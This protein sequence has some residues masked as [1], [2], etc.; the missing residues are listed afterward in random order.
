[1][2]N[3]LSQ[4]ADTIIKKIAGEDFDA[5]MQ[6]IKFSA[7]GNV[8]RYSPGSQFLIYDRKPD[9]VALGSYDTWV[10]FNRKPLAH[11]SI[12]IFKVDNLDKRFQNFNGLIW[13]VSDTYSK[14]DFNV[15]WDFDDISRKYVTSLWG[16]ED[17]FDTIKNLT[18]TYVRDIFETEENKSFIA[19]M[20]GFIISS[21]LGVDYEVSDRTEKYY[22][23]LK[24]EEKY[25]FIKRIQKHIQKLS[26]NAI[27]FADKHRRA[28]KEGRESYDFSK[29]KSINSDRREIYE[30]EQGGIYGSGSE[31]GYGSSTVTAD[32]RSR[33]NS[34]DGTS[35]GTGIRD[36]RLREGDLSGEVRDDDGVRGDASIRET[37]SNGSEGIKDADRREVNGEERKSI[38][39]TNNVDGNSERGSFVQTTYVGQLDLFNY[40][41]ISK[42]DTVDSHLD[43][44]HAINKSISTSKI[45]Q[46]YIDDVIKR[47]TGTV[48][49]KKR[50][51]D[52]F[53]INTHSSTEKV[54]FLK[55]EL[56]NY[57]AG[58]PL[59][60]FGLHGYD[61]LPSKGIEFK[62]RDQDGEKSGVVSYPNYAKRVQTLINT[63]KYFNEPML[64]FGESLSHDIGINL[65]A[66]YCGK[67]IAS[68]KNHI[69]IFNDNTLS[70]KEKFYAINNT[71]D[72]FF[73]N[74]GNNN[75]LSFKGEVEDTV[76][77]TYPAVLNGIPG[78]AESS[79]TYLE[80]YNAID[81]GLKNN[82]ELKN[83]AENTLLTGDLPAEPDPFAGT[84]TEAIELLARK[85]NVFDLQ[86][87]MIEAL[88]RDENINKDDI[89]QYL[90]HISVSH[91]MC[92][93]N[94]DFGLV[95]YSFN[96]NSVDVSFK[97]YDGKRH[98][99]SFTYDALVNVF[100]DVSK[101]FGFADTQRTAELHKKHS[102][103]GVYNDCIK[104]YYEFLD[105]LFTIKDKKMYAAIENSNICPDHSVGFINKM[106]G[107]NRYRIVVLGNEGGLQCYPDK[108]TFFDTFEEAAVFINSRAAEFNI[109]DY[110]RIADL[111]GISSSQIISED[112]FVEKVEG[113]VEDAPVNSNSESPY[114]TWTVAE[115][116][117]FHD[118]GEYYDD[119]ESLDEAVKLFDSIPSERMNGIKA[120]GIQ[121]HNLGIDSIYDDLQLDVF[122]GSSIDLE[123]FDDFPRLK[124][125]DLAINKL[126]EIVAM[127]PMC[128]TR[129]VLPETSNNFSADIELGQSVFLTDVDEQKCK[130]SYFEFVITDISDDFV[131]L[132]NNIHCQNIMY[133]EKVRKYAGVSYD[134]AKLDEYLLNEDSLY[135]DINI[136]DTCIV[137]GKIATID[138]RHN[139]WGQLSLKC[140]YDDGVHII[141]MGCSSFNSLREHPVIE[142]V[143]E[144]YP[145]QKI[146]IDGTEFIVQEVRDNDVQLLDPLLVY[147]VFRVESKD[148]VRSY[149]STSVNSL[150]SED[151]S[152]ISYDSVTD[153]FDSNEISGTPVNF[154][155][156]DTYV[157]NTG[158]DIS[159]FDKNIEAIK[160]LKV[161]ESENRFATK[162]EQKVL[163]QYIG[164]GGLSSCFDEDKN[165]EQFNILKEVLTEDEFISARA[166]TTD[167]FYT[168]REVISS[169]YTALENMGFSGGNVLEPSCGIGN[170]ISGMPSDMRKNS[171]I[172]GVEIDSISG[173]IAKALHPNVDI[174]IT[175]FEKSVLQ[176]NF[177]DVVI[178]NIPFGDFKVYDA[179]YNK[180]NFLIHDYFIAKC[181]DKV[182][183][184]GIVA[185][186]TS[187]GTLDKNNSKVRQ[188]FAERAELLGAIR[189][190]SN[191]FKAG[192]NTEATSDILFF[193]KKASRSIENSET[194]PWLDLGYTA[195]DIAVNQY[196]VDKPFMC[197]GKMVKDTSRF[198]PDRAITSCEA[199]DDGDSLYQKM[200]KA[201]NMLPDIKLD[202]IK[203]DEVSADNK[204]GAIPA[205]DSV[206]NNTYTVI[207]DEVYYRINS[208][209]YPQKGEMS[210][211]AYERVKGLCKVREVFHAYMDHQIARAS[212]D[213]IKED[214]VLLN[215]VYDDF[216]K[217]FGYI[218]KVGN[219]RANEL[220]FNDDVE[221]ALL[222]SLE[223]V[224]EEGVTKAECFNKQTIRPVIKIDKVD[225]AIDALNITLNEENTVDIHQMLSLYDVTFEQLISELKGKIYR[226]PVK[227]DEN[228]NFTGWES[229][230]EYLSGNVR[231][232]LEQAKTAA[233]IYPEYKE[234]VVALEA[235]I[236]KD[237]TASDI[238]VTLGMNWI[239][240]EDYEKFYGELLDLQSYYRERIKIKFDKFSHT[241]FIDSKNWA[242]SNSNAN[243]VF[244]T[245]R[246]N[247][248]EIIEC[249]LNMKQIVVQDK[250]ENGKYYVNQKETLLAREKA[251]IIQQ[252][253]SSWFWNDE[254]RYEKYIRR[255]NDTFNNTVLRQ[256][257]GTYMTFPGMNQNIVLKPHQKN[258]IARIV[259]SGNT[260]LAHAV[261]AGK[262]FEMAAAC[263]ELRRLGLA[264]KPLIVVP[265]HLTNQMA[266]EFMTLYPNA[267]ILLTTKKDFQKE[268]RKRF[269]SKITTGDYDAVIIG[270]SQFE[271]IPI[272][273]ERQQAY[274][275]SEI[276][277]LMQYI[278]ASKR[279]SGQIWT[280]KNME[281]TLKRLKERQEKLANEDYKDNV[282]TFEELGVDALFVDEAH[283]FKNLDFNTK[284]TRVA[285]IN[286]SG[287]LRAQD[288]FLKT[289][290]IQELTPGKN[291]VFATGTPIAN[292]MCEMYIM[293]KY[294][295]QDEL[296][297]L[298][299]DHFDAWAANFG[300]VV[301]SM[302]LAPEG[303][304]YR[305]K[306]RFAK[307]KNL[308]E[309]ITLFR[310]F[311]DVQTSD[312]LNLD[313]PKLVN[314]NGE[315]GYTIIESE[316]DDVVKEY[317]TLLT[318]RARHIHDGNVDPS[319]DNML[320]VCHDGRLVACDARLINPEIEP[321]ASSK[322]NLVVDNI[323]KKYH[324]TADI[325]GTQ[326]VFSD[327]GTPKSK[328]TADWEEKIKKSYSESE[329]N[330]FDV[331]NYL[332]TELVKRGIPEDEICFI[333]S[334]NS[335][336]QKDKMFSDMR[337]GTKRIILG[338]TE[339]MGTG[340]NI[341]KR[342]VA[343][344]ELGC[345]WR[346]AD[347]EQ[348]EGRILRQGNINENVEI[349]RYVTKGTFDA[350]N[351]NIIVNKQKFISQVMT[352]H[353]T[354][355]ECDDVDD[356]SLSYAEVMAIA[357]GNPYIKE[358][359]EVELE[360]K[361]LHSLKR[362]Y[363]DTAMHNKLTVK[364]LPEK[365]NKNKETIEKIE[366]DIKNRN[367]Y[368]ESHKNEEGKLIFDI[369]IND[370]RFH[371]KD[372][373]NDY[374]NLMLD[375]T[376]VGNSFMG[377]FCGFDVE[378][379][380][381]IS[382]LGTNNKFV[383]IHGDYAYN[384]ELGKDNV[385]ILF[386][387][388][389]NDIDKYHKLCL[390]ILVRDEKNFD[391]LNKELDKPFEF[392]EKLQTLEKRH[393][394]LIDF[395]NE[396]KKEDKNIEDASNDDISD[397]TYDSEKVVC[398]SR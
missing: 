255:Y 132:E 15:L 95:K 126:G 174:Q 102:W 200:Q 320:K 258:A 387:G 1:M 280:V 147:P 269:I 158:S 376:P 301:T 259:R 146:N 242:D 140:S 24:M 213:V 286:S 107:E 396:D 97:D 360:L 134:A 3:I 215:D 41:N 65:V 208:L 64:S 345:P 145:G 309:L 356:A 323:V 157:P 223:V 79:F 374:I 198:G 111:A 196:F 120:I 13:D 156:D 44:H 116:S 206:K 58:W 224:T 170:F 90:K 233:N 122:T 124:E 209:M 54:A 352:G 297:Q 262:S 39:D 179:K 63:G 205:I 176:D 2:G 91:D 337:N 38:N 142:E 75:L 53:I 375:K 14:S 143:D 130:D 288:M 232:K 260:L 311:A 295:Q 349:F 128:E 8:Y 284:M 69:S 202:V 287:S 264:N 180:N 229:A 305:E 173:R 96:E 80:L 326:I 316:P 40:F 351:W 235:V 185:L 398:K 144:F 339:K 23:S 18:R 114:I 28:L 181:L 56:G 27:L 250:D 71:D 236:P 70:Y 78:Y 74:F 217:K 265:N 106:T 61:C 66:F 222:C 364:I 214:Q 298:G 103:Y 160:M 273:K 243:T 109:V 267:N 127:F 152:D 395:L 227:A 165:P 329:V 34:E 207:N 60:G 338:S 263:M 332:K 357:S 9:A 361:K 35:R 354:A 136:G 310:S 249:L 365:I 385:M 315:E 162:D 138:I 244:G 52:Y 324:E 277:E 121:C 19:D 278:E 253:F 26:K 85:G 246:K 108:E 359:N 291:V 50:V 119:I 167:A 397:M 151:N 321:S 293:Q 248:L 219:N 150:D 131:T 346:P 393:K 191:T 231:E 51:Y 221:Y 43:F 327:I 201:V 178:G 317:M 381:E 129:G 392:S 245:K 135:H 141:S 153:S 73:K 335:D 101:E 308:P 168:P 55:K 218:S 343:L 386:N 92:F 271:K 355:R 112:S 45:P 303:Q 274:I 369:E 57:G 195:D 182:A 81:N 276:E 59:D 319:E 186:L 193:R 380:K 149:I 17:F 384:K 270:F 49:G 254:E 314:S 294:L 391:V 93:L 389:N 279:D 256:Y 225:S 283:Y 16:G 94:N 331:Y 89:E 169:I 212:E 204:L 67:R 5:Y 304:T 20:S 37:E 370:I 7:R 390:D 137:D 247:A 251:E 29:G 155:Y 163:A 322:L 25:L 275:D 266:S 30:N 190:P 100:E 302:E 115:V 341:Q 377:K 281:S 98:E 272:S 268:R 86:H 4:R 72:Y 6:F 68:R 226:N 164:W 368:F 10:S 220:A 148:F 175:G 83:L 21:R 234:N 184:G 105:Y 82:D 306:T 394:E 189:L 371:E 292:T 166:S 99:E 211:K 382:F 353:S 203:D 238:N 261:G 172:Y 350:Y 154:S 118:M 347:V 46:E 210:D 12:P 333:H 159:R 48:G 325:K 241:Y 194:A 342:A 237:L 378:F 216:V 42:E 240:N 36:T 362:S 171:N 117:E 197:L 113:T 139:V 192:A 84:L 372:K 188:Y 32:D 76:T 177:F 285:G 290:Y 299:I 228:D 239:D 31:R 252:K 367:N 388:I 358:L 373:A 230:E 125:C 282:I 363:D 307:F 199:L 22:N 312:M 383:I 313:I 366:N 330:N 289:R 11:K 77:I 336:V 344:H 87:P 348:Q 123:I 296:K 187:K 318:E 110:D 161:I 257:D 183:T 328:W 47:G 104:D 334:A 133:I 62:W 379:K 88:F 300:E 340:T 33:D